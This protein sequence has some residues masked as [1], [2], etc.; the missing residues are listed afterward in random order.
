MEFQPDILPVS[1][2]FAV[3]EKPLPRPDVF[4]MVIK[5]TRIISEK[6]LA[7]FLAYWAPLSYRIKGFARVENSK[8]VAIQCTPGQI[9]IQ[10]VS[11][12]P[13]P[14][15]MIALTD[16]FTLREWNHSFKDHLQ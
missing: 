1:R 11:F 9:N 4:S 12:W 13:G 10:P 3:L 2:F 6:R 15:E 8:T 7:E 14:T 5:T 16:R